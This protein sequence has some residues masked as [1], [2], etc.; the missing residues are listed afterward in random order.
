MARITMKNVEFYLGL[1]N[2]QLADRGITDFRYAVHDAN[3]YKRLVLK[4]NTAI[5]ACLT[6]SGCT[7]RELYEQVHAVYNTLLYVK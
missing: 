1:C 4:E 6:P 2:G 7:T 5:K 3:G